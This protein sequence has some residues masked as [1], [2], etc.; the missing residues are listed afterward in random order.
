MKK[1]MY[2]SVC[3]ALFPAPSYA[4]KKGK[5]AL[6]EIEKAVNTCPWQKSKTKQISWL[7]AIGKK[8]IDSIM[9]TSQVKTSTENPIKK[10]K[11]RS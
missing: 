7:E 5:I 6:P 4:Q 11:N 8:Q 10:N 2:F 9:G 3:F 1:Y